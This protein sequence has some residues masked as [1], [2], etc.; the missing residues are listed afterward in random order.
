MIFSVRA[1]RTFAVRVIP[2]SPAAQQTWFG[3]QSVGERVA[4][5]GAPA[6]SFLL[7]RVKVFHVYSKGGGGGGVYSCHAWP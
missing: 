3:S 5:A 7:V 2:S 1:G 6:M 4:F